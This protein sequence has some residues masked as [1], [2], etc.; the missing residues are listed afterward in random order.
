V[1]EAQALPRPKAATGVVFVDPATRTLS[2]RLSENES[3]YSKLLFREGW[4]RLRRDR[5][6]GWPLGSE[7]VWADVPGARRVVHGQ[8]ADGGTLSFHFP[9]GTPGYTELVGKPGLWA[10]VTMDTATR[11]ILAVRFLNGSA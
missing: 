1:T 6:A 8:P 4:S 11:R 9:P 5:E 2:V 7:W 10:V 3:G